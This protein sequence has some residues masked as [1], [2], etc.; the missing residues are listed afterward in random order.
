MTTRES[1]S[2]RRPSLTV[3]LNFGGRRYAATIGY[4]PDG[5]PSEVFAKGAKIGS[6]MDAILDDASILVSLLLQ[7]G[8]E[9]AAISKSMSRIRDGEAA[10]VV[11]ALANLIA[12]E[13]GEE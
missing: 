8:V 3:D 6:G 7:H 11:G 9:P 12:S 4:F 1:L 2:Q 10:S 5:R 13:A